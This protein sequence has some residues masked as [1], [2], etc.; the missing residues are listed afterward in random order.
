MCGAHQFFFFSSIGDELDNDE[1]NVVILNKKSIVMAMCIVRRKW[2]SFRAVISI[3]TLPKYGYFGTFSEKIEIF[4]IS[5]PTFGYAPRA[6]TQILKISVFPE[7]VP[8]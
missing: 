6:G 5:L 3:N 7:N 8:K 1:G 2:L 4:K